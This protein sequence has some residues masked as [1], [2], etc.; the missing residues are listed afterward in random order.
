[1]LIFAG[2]SLAS[3][4]TLASPRISVAVWAK[5]PHAHKA[6]AIATR[7]RRVVF[8]ANAPELLLFGLSVSRQKLSSPGRFPLWELPKWQDRGNCNETDYPFSVIA[9]IF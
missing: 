8:K 6:N 1:M 7:G 2:G 3:G 4:T 9:E 5:T